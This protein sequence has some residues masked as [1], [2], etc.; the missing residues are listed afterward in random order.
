MNDATKS[1]TSAKASRSGSTEKT[2]G[3]QGTSAVDATT[4]T[5]QP[6]SEQ[7]PVGP[8]EAMMAKLGKT[9]FIALFVRSKPVDGFWRCAR[10]WPHDGAHVFVVED[11]AAAHQQYDADVF[12]DAAALERLEQ[13]QMLF[14]ERQHTQEKEA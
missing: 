7:S 8:Q 6:D 9:A 1:A 2:T 12:I 11:P 10:F 3:T 13:E 4:E 14:V 5:P